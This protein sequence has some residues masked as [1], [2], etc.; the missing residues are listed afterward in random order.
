MKGAWWIVVGLAIVALA[1]SL[2]SVF[3]K[4]LA[5]WDSRLAAAEAE[6]K[7]LDIP[8]PSDTFAD[9]QECTVYGNGWS[10]RLPPKDCAEIHRNGGYHHNHLIEMMVETI[11]A[12]KIRPRSRG[13]RLG[14]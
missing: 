8:P 3:G 6:A 5:H 7:L 2:G 13:S 4:A 12:K 1:G 9:E 14:P 10:S 11:P